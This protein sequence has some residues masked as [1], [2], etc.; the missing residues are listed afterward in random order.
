[1][2][3]LHHSSSLTA[4]IF[5]LLPAVFSWATHRAVLASEAA[6]VAERLTAARTRVLGVWALCAGG[7]V[8][9]ASSSAWWA[10]PLSLL[11]LACV[12]HRTRRRLFG[13]TASLPASLA[14]RL[15][16]LVASAG[17]WILLGSV[18]ALATV[19]PVPWRAPS[20][21]L[22]LATLLLWQHCERRI[23]LSLV[24]ATPLERPDLQE[25]FGSVLARAGVRQ[26][27][28]WRA[29]APGH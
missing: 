7:L 28:T 17:F 12:S 25:R 2:R 5:A 14:Q 8:A 3:F 11:A 10:I 21:I 23:T 20:L 19:A 24:G 15:R 29:G 9:G 6:T 22:L 27:A 1:M 16:W 13:E 4:C 18:P 26:P